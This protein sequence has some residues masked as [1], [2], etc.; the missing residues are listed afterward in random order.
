MVWNI[1]PSSDKARTV[2]N[3]EQHHNYICCEGYTSGCVSSSVTV[4]SKTVT[5]KHVKI[6]TYVQHMMQ[7]NPDGH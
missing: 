1:V 3:P 2:T 7:L 6:S 4:T 5:A